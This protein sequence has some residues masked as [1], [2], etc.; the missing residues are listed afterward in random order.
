MKKILLLALILTGCSKEYN[1]IKCTVGNQTLIDT[2]GYDI[3]HVYRIGNGVFVSDSVG[4]M[5]CEYV[6]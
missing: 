3:D 6:Y 5:S 1:C 4:V 2:C